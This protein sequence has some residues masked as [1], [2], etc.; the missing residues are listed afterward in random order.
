L[1]PFWQRTLPVGKVLRVPCLVAAAIVLLSYVL[2]V[3][4]R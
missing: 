3:L 4:S 2:F 1:A